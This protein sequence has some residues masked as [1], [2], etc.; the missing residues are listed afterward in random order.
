MKDIFNVIQDTTQYDKSAYNYTKS[1]I[2]SDSITT[3]EINWVKY[4]HI[5]YI[6]QININSICDLI[7]ID[8]NIYKLD[9]KLKIINK[10]NSSFNQMMNCTNYTLFR[11]QDAYINKIIDNKIIANIWFEYIINFTIEDHNQIKILGEY[12]KYIKLNYDKNTDRNTQI[13][14][15]VSIYAEWT[16]KYLE[17][18]NVAFEFDETFYKIN[19]IYKINMILLEPEE[20]HKYRLILI[21]KILKLFKLFLD[22]VLKTN[23][24]IHNNIIET[25]SIISEI[26]PNYNLY[27]I[28]FSIK[29]TIINREVSD[30]VLLD[31]LLKI[32]NIINNSE[33]ILII[34]NYVKLYDN[35]PLLINHLIE[36][37][38]SKI[39]NPIYPKD[40]IINEIYDILLIISLYK[41]K[42]DLWNIYLSY[43][44]NRIIY[45]IR[46]NNITKMI[47]DYELSIFEILIIKKCSDFSKTTKQLLNNISAS[48]INSINYQQCKYNIIYKTD[49]IKPFDLSDINKVNF[50]MIDK[51][52][53]DKCSSKQILTN[54]LIAQEKYPSDF[55]QYLTVGEAYFQKLYELY[56]INYLI[57]QSIIDISFNNINI[58]CNIIQ[59]TIIYHVINDKYTIKE[60]IN[61]I[62]FDKNCSNICNYLDYY[63]K[64]LLF[65]K[66]LII[67]DNKL[68]ISENT[69]K[70]DISQ[71]EINLQLTNTIVK[72]EVE[73]IKSVEYL[74]YMILT[75]MFKH[76]STTSFKLDTIIEDVFTYI[77]YANLN[78]NLKDIFKIDQVELIRCINYIEKRDIIEEINN[79]E[80]KYIV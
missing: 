1:I 44:Y 75:R 66:I 55:K 54:K 41:N 62:A 34:G 15:F 29:W 65:N 39:K 73:D 69:I 27:L 53:H 5:F 26:N 12:L 28:D 38:D 57:E 13:N 18:Y 40:T 3:F 80:Y 6:E 64:N 74:R 22:N 36:V 10:L 14:I 47:I 78:I 25:F 16:A 51:L 23:S 11:L 20:Q 31:N 45:Y 68:T 46:S 79:K 61:Y 17:K 67:I 48:I 56:Q 77:D 58:I 33:C 76:N 42:E 52:I 43:L 24:Y 30:S 9:S 2:E 59:Y 19:N 8:I 60:L 4:Q 63:I 49:K 72:L 70:L 50:I 37:L 35:R 32:A 7:T 71:I 21:T